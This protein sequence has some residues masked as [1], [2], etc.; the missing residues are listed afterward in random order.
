[1]RS[2][3][4]A[5]ALLALSACA[6]RGPAFTGNARLEYNEA[7][8]RS[9]REE[10][11]LNV[12]RLRYLEGPEFLSVGSIAS[13]LRF[14][15]GA[16]AGG[17][18]GDDQSV[19]TRIVTPGGSFGYSEQPVTTFAPRQDEAF[20][21]G[22]VEPVSLETFV[23]L[24]RYGWSLERALLV[25]VEE[26]N[27]V[28]NVSSR[29]SLGAADV[30]A[31]E[32]FGAL[33]RG[34]QALHER[35]WLTVEAVD[36]WQSVSAEIPAESVTA[37]HHIDAAA[38]GY[39]LVHA[40]ARAAYELQRPVRRYVLRLSSDARG[41]ADARALLGELGLP[42]RGEYELVD[43]VG[44]EHA[45][46]GAIALRTRSVIGAL[47]YLSQGVAVPADD[48]AA[49][50]AEAGAA[51]VRVPLRISSA[52]E[53]PATAALAVQ[54]GERWFYIEAA[55]FDSRRTFGALESLVR[56]QVGAGG[57]ADTPVL[58]LPVAR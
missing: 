39:R 2:A 9:G 44:A 13:Q 41:S 45:G 22:L 48:I 37:E 32:R 43:A 7:V 21:R 42:E 50:R 55:D 24:T 47:A 57:V 4:L 12:V 30:A 58:T 18:F 6:L 5:L 3:A 15:V 56:L 33:A 52:S 16:T 46:A 53:R 40:A 17:T 10:L 34:V 38:S 1:M 36:D 11:L 14:E 54:S 20:M 51:S 19:P 49:G 26:L 31:G 23:A 27:G 25:V 35:R 8:Q 28:R 29:E